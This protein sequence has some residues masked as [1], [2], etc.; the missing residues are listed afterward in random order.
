MASLKNQREERWK[1]ELQ[2]ERDRIALVG[3]L[4][5]VI[6]TPFETKKRAFRIK[7][8]EPLPPDQ[9]IDP[10]RIIFGEEHLKKFDAQRLQGA[11]KDLDNASEKI[12]AFRYLI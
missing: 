10:Q 12:S 1:R 3:H 2:K 6:Q 7:N 5:S 11:S 9:Q 8:F 4:G